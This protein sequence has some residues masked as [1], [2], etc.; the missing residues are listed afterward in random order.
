MPKMKTNRLT[1]KKFRVTANGRIKRRCAFKSHNTAKKSPKR[2]R[3]L[4]SRPLTDAANMRQI[5]SL[6]PYG[7]K[8]N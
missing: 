8:G 2:I 1:K 5:T 6:L 4:R 3:Q 7:R